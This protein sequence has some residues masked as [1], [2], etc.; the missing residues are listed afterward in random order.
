MQCICTVSEHFLKFPFTTAHAFILTGKD[1]Q[2]SWIY[3]TTGSWLHASLAAT[4]ICMYNINVCVCAKKISDTT[5]CLLLISN[6]NFKLTKSF[7]KVCWHHMTH[8]LL[9]SC[10]LLSD[11]CVG[12]NTGLVNTV[13]CVPLHMLEFYFIHPKTST[14]RAMCVHTVIVAAWLR[15]VFGAQRK[16]K[17]LKLSHE[18][19]KAVTHCHL[20]ACTLFKGTVSSCLRH[21]HSELFHYTDLTP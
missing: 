14:Q 5:A 2:W 10:W 3:L 13:K 9:H 19:L 8:D 1:C 16:W 11:Q 7:R 21:V 18:E 20:V 6:I 17:M 15:V 4:C 12:I